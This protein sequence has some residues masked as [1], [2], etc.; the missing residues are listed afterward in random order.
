[1]RYNIEH[2]LPA[3]ELGDPA[4]FARYVEWLDGMLR[5][6]GVDTADVVRCLEL[7]R[8]ECGRRYPDDDPA[9]RPIIDAGLSAVGAT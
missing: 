4:M 7:L 5:S 8:D 9:I 3:V 6:R 1:M 2:L